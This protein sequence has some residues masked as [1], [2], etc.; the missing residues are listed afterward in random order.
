[1]TDKKIEQLTERLRELNLQQ[2]RVISEL[3]TLTGASNELPVNSATPD[4]EGKS[5]KI[6]DGVRIIN[7]GK[8][9][10]TQGTITKIGKLVTIRLRT[11]QTTVRK[12]TNLLLQ[13]HAGR[14]TTSTK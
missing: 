6:G 12:S 8:F 10:E 5:L 14:N 11:G 3:E 9:K 7:K 1:M 4:A 2:E 13:Q